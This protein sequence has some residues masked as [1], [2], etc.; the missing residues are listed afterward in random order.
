MH[1]LVIGTLLPSSP[2]NSRPSSS[3]L[4]LFIT[5]QTHYSKRP[6]LIFSDSLSSL[7][8]ISNHL[9]HQ[10]VHRIQ[11][12]LHAFTVPHNKSASLFGY[13]AEPYSPKVKKYLVPFHF[14][15]TTLLHCVA[16]SFNSV[17]TLARSKQAR[18]LNHRTSNQFRTHG[19]PT[20]RLFISTTENFTGPTHALRLRTTHP[21]VLHC[22]EENLSSRA[23]F[24]NCRH[25]G[26]FVLPTLILYC[27]YRLSKFIG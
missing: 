17:P 5:F 23:A 16:S 21:C 3:T 6:V 20:R 26:H 24:C 11:L 8:A 1:P 22:T 25:D 14:D 12:L 2:P 13:P 15:L 18:Q 27:L 9:E 10:T 19:L 4:K 7:Q